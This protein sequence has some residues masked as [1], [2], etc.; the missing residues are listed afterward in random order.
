MRY[1][2]ISFAWE[3]QFL[4]IMMENTS[5]YIFTLFV[6]AFG[7]FFLP[8]FV[9][10]HTIPLLTDLLDEPSKGKAAGIVLF[11]STVGS[12]FGSTVTSIVLFEWIGV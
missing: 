1:V 7:L 8:V 11:A 5:S 9:A 3:R 10:S 6:V 2:S 4:E 12:F